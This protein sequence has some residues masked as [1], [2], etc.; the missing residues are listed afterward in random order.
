MNHKA[1]DSG[2]EPVCGS[3]IRCITYG[4]RRVMELVLAV[5]FFLD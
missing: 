4:L 1:G 5:L 2:Y 3:L